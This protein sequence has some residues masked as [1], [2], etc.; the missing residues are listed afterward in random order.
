[1]RT[2]LFFR[3]SMFVLLL[4]SISVFLLPTTAYTQCGETGYIRMISRPVGGQSNNHSYSANLSADGRY[5]VF[6]SESTGF[7]PN[8]T[9]MV[10]D[11]FLYDTQTCQYERVSDA[12]DG[13]QANGM[14][15]TFAISSDARYIAFTTWAT[16]LIP[17]DTVNNALNVY[18]RD[19]QLGT[20]I[21]IRAYDGS[22]PLSSLEYPSMS[23][24]GRYI[25]FQSAAWNLIP[26][27][28][29]ERQ[30]IFVY[31]RQTN[32][33]E[34]I[35]E[36]YDGQQSN[37][38]S[39]KP[40][41]AAEGRY[42]V[43]ASNA[44]NWVS[45]EPID[46]QYDLYRYDRQ[47]GVVQ[48]VNVA[49]NGSLV[50]SP[51]QHVRPS[52]DGEYILFGAQSNG[53]FN[54]PINDLQVRIIRRDMVAAQN[55]LVSQTSDGI[56]TNASSFVNYLSPNG[57][58]ALYSTESAQFHSGDTN[59]AWDVIVRDMQT[60]TSRLVSMTAGGIVG[61][62]DSFDGVISAD[63]RYV[64]FF[65]DASN[66][67]P[68]D[69]NNKTDVFLVDLNQLPIPPTSTPTPTSTFTNTPTQ[70]LT[71][72]NSRTP[73]QTLSP[74]HTRTATETF[75]PTATFTAS[76][77]PLATNTF[78]PVP[79]QCPFDPLQQI[80][81]RASGQAPNGTGGNGA[82]ED[83]LAISDDGRFIAF[84][85]DSSDLVP[86]DTNNRP[87]IFVY[88]RL[89]CALERVS[90]SSTGVEGTGFTYFP[91][92]SGNGRF[93]S[94][95]SNSVYTTLD[96]NGQYDTYV[97][98]RWTGQTFLG[99]AK[100]DGT[101]AGGGAGSFSQDGRYLLFR[102]ISP[103]V[104][105]NSGGNCSVIVRDL[106]FGG[107]T[108][109]TVIAPFILNLRLSGNGRYIVFSSD[110]LLSPSDSGQLYDVYR[111]DRD[112]PGAAPQLISQSILGIGG[113]QD[114]G[115]QQKTDISY[116]GRQIVFESKATN[117]VEYDGAAN[118]D[119]FVWDENQTPRISRVS[120]TSGGMPSFGE[121]WYPSISNN[122][123]YVA[124][125]SSLALTSETASSGYV[126][127][128][129]V[130]DRVTGLTRLVT[131]NNSLQPSTG[132]RP[133]ISGD[134]QV[135]AFMTGTPLTPGDTNVF[136]D[137]Y[138]TNVALLPI[139][140][141]GSD[142]LAD[143]S[144][145]QS[146]MS[147][148]MGGYN[149]FWIEYSS[150][151]GS[152][153]C[154]Q[155]VCG[156]GGGTSRPDT[157]QYWV[158][159]GGNVEPEQ[160]YVTQTVFIPSGTAA[161]SFR[162]M[163]PYD[164]A[165]SAVFRVYVDNAVVWEL[166]KPF[167]D[168]GANYYVTANINLN[169]YANNARHQILFYGE[170]NNGVTNMH[171]DT[172]SLI[173][174][175]T[176]VPPTNTPTLTPTNSQTPTPSDTPTQ[177]YT[178]SATHTPTAT[179]T[180]SA[181]PTETPS[182]T[183]TATP[184]DIPPLPPPVGTAPLGT[185]NSSSP[186]FTWN[187]VPGATWYYLW[188]GRGDGLHMLDQWYDGFYICT[189]GTCSVT[190]DLALLPGW[191]QWWVQAWSLE[192]GYSVW[193]AAHDFELPPVT[194]NTIAPVGAITEPIPSFSW[195][196][197][198]GMTWYYVWVSGPGGVHILDQWNEAINL[199][200]AG[201][202]TLSPNIPLQ[203]GTHRWWVQAWNPITGYTAW[204]SETIFALPFV[205]PT[206]LAPLGTINTGAPTFT[207]SQLTGAAWYYLWVSSDSGHVID[208]WY[209][210]S[211][212][213]GGTCSV[214]PPLSLPA[215][216]YRWWIQAWSPEDGYSPW[217]AESNFSV[218]IPDVPGGDPELPPEIVPTEPP[219]PEVEVTEQP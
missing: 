68:G 4:F 141:A 94:F 81:Q 103:G 48:R 41:I 117:L 116:D 190:P 181:T 160:G 92:I 88:D 186:T 111:I 50:A 76:N 210:L 110:T 188:V 20:L 51:S 182:P 108:C 54:P 219:P 180:P 208:Q 12:L 148:G 183:P 169:A 29:N 3:L 13:T 179:H 22:E 201:V 205:A 172:V 119:V 135:V 177:T 152:P 89:S 62:A 163:V 198:P 43:F 211:V 7:V 53:M 74:T 66:L 137:A 25:A 133:V 99:S 122:G 197:I 71:P 86:G 129:Y 134:G 30:D 158:W 18:V 47:S 64:T 204:N 168:F 218:S 97:R 59:G 212:C 95:M 60:G 153:V 90:V 113:D 56:P 150:N 128:N 171:L 196:H 207:W 37:G 9:N 126:Y 83:E 98:D 213:G 36:G 139:F 31:D 118:F 154:N 144:F 38:F 8:D 151:F 46:T 149:P 147:S 80:N 187:A 120:V 55:Q 65:S 5:V 33:L 67:V 44:T 104:A 161:L 216:N 107:A 203:G 15:E 77:T 87:D 185:I 45:G 100:L 143:G 1:M 16:N 11:L 58:W 40:R 130:H 91:D 170:T 2:S 173:W 35:W 32:S 145:D 125:R 136:N 101:S 21:R 178:P 14:V 159:L 124:F 191:H 162:L 63:G 202:C 19:R 96:T 106:F 156:D 165:G 78:T 27:D 195:N 23:A 155:A 42:V 105:P 24:D 75:T 157:G 121:S 49:A 140:R 57:R 184:T 6:V 34:R 102:S 109:Y 131:Y 127:R 52:G 209:Q 166:N 215:G 93:V 10:R 115:R 142:L 206:P 193:S 112:Q 39:E 138:V 189:G 217:S 199:C 70:T 123:R 84:R 214:T 79:N 176:F 164:T 73:T 72:T 85:S 17:G 200:A 175:G 69:T 194:V 28:T 82:V 132:D 146:N 61:N 192:N 114:S 26:G 167:G 174:N